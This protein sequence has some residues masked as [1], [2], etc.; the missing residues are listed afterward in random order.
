MGNAISRLTPV[1][2]TAFVTQ[3][4]RALDSR[5][6]TPILGDTLADDIVS[7]IAYD[8]DAMGVPSSAVRQTA[9]RAKMLDDRVRRFVAEHPDAVV[10]DLGAGLGTAM[11]RVA[12][13]PTVDWYS[14]D[15]P[16]VIAL[17]D[18][19][20]PEGEQAHSVAASLTDDSWTDQIPSDRPTVLIADGLLAFLPESV[21][22]T[23]FRRIPEYFSSGEIA[24]NDYGR[25]GRLN[26]AAMKIVFSAVG[27]QWAYR[28]FSDPHV[29][30]SWS[31]RLRLVEE[32][33]LSHAPE[34]DL[35]PVA[36]RVSTR[37]MGMTKSGARTARILRYR[38]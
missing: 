16:N 11:M 29:P 24:M 35:Y 6:P 23:L 12:P 5:W 15:L 30:E 14:V 20:V 34:I 31:P 22:V 17:R 27:T 33:S 3:Y 18:E 13:P 9:L 19:L 21:V 2:L 7:K 4:A 10:V 26:I 37:L 25:V 32:T 8:F 36:A 38:F 28:G 1:E